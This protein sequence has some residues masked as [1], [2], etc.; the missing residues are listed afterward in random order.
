MEDASSAIGWCR[1]SFC[2]YLMT[3]YSF[4]EASLSLFKGKPTV[5]FKESEIGSL[6]S[7]FNLCLI[8]KFSYGKS[9][10][11]ILRREFSIV[12][13]KGPFKVERLNW[14]HTLVRFDLEDN[15]MGLWL[16]GL[17]HFHGF[18]MRVFRWSTYFQLSIEPLIILVWIALEGFPIH[19]FNK[20]FT[21]STANLIGKT[22]TLADPKTSLSR[23]SIARICLEY[24]LLKALPNE[25]W[26]GTS[27]PK[28]W[29]TSIMRIYH[30]IVLIG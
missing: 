15:Y 17:W 13:F 18:P 28:V 6:A 4:C 11:E 30:L 2:S 29:K 9:P 16:K 26:I 21:F 8:R 5:F 27:S 7:P 24:N 14:K 22:L 23:S 25:I 12:G 10:M 19:F 20:S 3:C 1:K